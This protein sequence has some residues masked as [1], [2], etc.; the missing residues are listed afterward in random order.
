MVLHERIPVFP[1]HAP[2]PQQSPLPL[3]DRRVRVA[4]MGV[5]CGAE[6][7][8]CW[9]V[10]RLPQLSALHSDQLIETMARSIERRCMNS[11]LRPGFGMLMRHDQE[12]ASSLSQKPPVAR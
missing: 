2:W 7:K 1:P 8:I 10:V 5:A 4:R 6:K 12:R 3:F 11:A 9:H